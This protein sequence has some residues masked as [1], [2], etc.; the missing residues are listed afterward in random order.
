MKV[1]Y[2]HGF[3]SSPQSSKAQFFAARFG[4]AGVECVIPALDGGDFANLTITAQLELIEREAGGETVRLIG[5]SLGG[6]LAALY[7]SLHP[8]ATDRVVLLAPAFCFGSY[9]PQ[10]LGP[11]I[12]EAWMRTGV[13]RIPHYGYHEERDLNYGF[14][15]DAVRYPDYP[16]FTAPALIMHGRNDEVVPVRVSETFAAV[17]SNARLLVLDSDH[18]LTDVTATLWKETS[19]FFGL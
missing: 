14:I 4:E 16:D 11:A 5:S 1:I 15:E 18:Q 12:L 7:A 19:A 8:Q 2:L 10:D 3:A 9:Y 17:H 6:Y 13:R